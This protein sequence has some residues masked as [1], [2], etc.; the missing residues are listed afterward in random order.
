MGGGC[1]LLVVKFPG[2]PL[3][4][5]DHKLRSRTRE[6][7]AEFAATVQVAADGV[8]ASTAAGRV[9][10]PAAP[11]ACLDRGH[12]C[13]PTP[14]ETTLPDPAGD[15]DSAGIVLRDTSWS[16]ISGKT[17]LPDPSRSTI[18]RKIVLPDA[19]G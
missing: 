19:P 7:V 18:S 12:S 16:M 2:E 15:P 9:F 1:K 11:C 13:P 14:A 5:Q 6:F 17:V 4:Q 10:S 3:S 8:A